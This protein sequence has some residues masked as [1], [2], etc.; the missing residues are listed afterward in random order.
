M[1]LTSKCQ[2]STPQAVRSKAGLQ[3]QSGIKFEVCAD[4]GALMRRAA[5]SASPIGGAFEQVFGC[6][7]AAQVKAMG[8]G[9]SV[10]FISG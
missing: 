10:V 7:N 3:P 6:A 9:E 8:T 4:S 5:V 2:V 1:R